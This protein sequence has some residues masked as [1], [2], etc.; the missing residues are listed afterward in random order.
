MIDFFGHQCLCIDAETVDESCLSFIKMN[1][2]NKESTRDSSM[3]DGTISNSCSEASTPREIVIDSILTDEDD[4]ENTETVEQ[5]NPTEE[6][7]KKNQKTIKTSGTQ[8]VFFM[9]GCQRSGSNWLRTMLSEH[10][11]LIAPHPPHIMRDFMPR[12]H[13]YGNLSVQQN[14]KVR[15]LPLKGIFTYLD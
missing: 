2:S 15:M 14:L 1:M 8:Q 7:Q 11:N 6:E 9:I 3:S 4:Y 5:T 12:L 10:E 13:K